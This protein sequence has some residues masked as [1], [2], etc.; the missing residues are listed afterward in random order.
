MF[1]RGAYDMKGGLAAMMCAVRDLAD[2]D[3][4]RVRFVCVPDEESEDIERRTSDELVRRGLRRRLRDHRRADRPARRHPGQGR[5]RLPAGGAR[6]RRARLDPVAG[7]QRGPEGHRR[8][9]PNRVIAVLARVVGAVRPAVD[10]P[11][12]HQRG[13]RAEQ[14]AR[15]VHHGD[16]HPLPAQPGPRRHPRAD[17]DDPGH[18]GRPHLHPP[19]R[20]RLALE[21]LRRRALGRRRADDQRRVDERRARRRLRRGVVPAR[22]HPGGRVRPGRRRA[23]RAR[24]VGL[25]LLAGPLPAGADRVRPPAAAAGWSGAS[26]RRRCARSRGASR[27]DDVGERRGAPAPRRPRADQA[28]AAGDGARRR[29]ER[30]RARDDR[31]PRDRRRQE[32]RSSAPGPPADRH[33]R[34]HQRGGGRRAHDHGPRLRRALR[35]QEGRAQAAL[36]HDP[37][38]PRRPEQE[39]DL[40]D[41]DPA[42]PRGRRSPATAP[43]RSTRPTSTAARA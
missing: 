36:G 42:R 11:R 38:R 14:G 18:G 33:P 34:G 21:P 43:T 10:Q 40:R 28:R 30:D 3:A 31:A 2:Q 32:R 35:G 13:R 22:G 1:G 19:A 20:A 7:R 25:D 5:A 27:R 12:A 6:P 41:V 29:D 15:R 23:P 8:L 24:G 4:V 26:P 9:P 16:R 37:A 39:R 17:P